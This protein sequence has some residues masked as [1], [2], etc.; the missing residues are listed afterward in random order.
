MVITQGFIIRRLAPRFGPA[1]IL[2]FSI[3]GLSAAVMINLAPTSLYWVYAVQPLLAISQGLTQPNITSII[4]SLG[5]TENQG[6]I[7]GIQASIQSLAF[8]IPP[9]L[10]GLISSIDYR[11]PVV[12]GS[13]CLLASGLIFVFVYKPQ[14]HIIKEAVV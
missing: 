9:I 7:L 10:A 5:T 4:S 12:A 14:M 13:L 2:R 3:L 8:A 1:Q 11:Y 6:E